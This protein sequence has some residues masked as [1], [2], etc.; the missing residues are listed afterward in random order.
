LDRFSGETNYHLVA[1]PLSELKW[2]DKVKNNQPALIMAE[3]VTMYLTA[4]ALH[5]T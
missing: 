4:L 1:S 3:G 2:I 5:K